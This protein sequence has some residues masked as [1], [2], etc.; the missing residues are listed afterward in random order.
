MSRTAFQP[1]TDSDRLKIKLA[2]LQRLCYACCQEKIKETRYVPLYAKK[3]A[4]EALL[5][6]KSTEGLLAAIA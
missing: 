3:N 6:A 2:V 5:Y 4:H 1:V